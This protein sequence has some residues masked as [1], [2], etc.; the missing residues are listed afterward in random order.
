MQTE[1]ISNSTVKTTKQNIYE[2]TQVWLEKRDKKRTDS[3]KRQE[4]EEIKYCTFH[5]N[6]CK[7]VN[8]SNNISL[9]RNL[10]Y[11]TTIHKKVLII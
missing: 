8:E 5:P 6:I 3:K 10:R 1:T 9:S 11:N 7:E 4:S 2:R